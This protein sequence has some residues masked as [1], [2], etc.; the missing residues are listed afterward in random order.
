LESKPS[1]NHRKVTLSAS[2]RKVFIVH[3]HD[4]GAREKVAR[5]LEKIDLQPIIL[6]EQASSGKTI[7]EKI[8]A[9]A[10]VGFAVVLV[11]PDDHGAV[12]GDQTQPRARQNVVLEL[13]Y[14]SAKLGRESVCILRKGNTEIPSDFAGVV[15]ID[16]DEA[17]HWQLALCRELK[18][19]GFAIDMNQVI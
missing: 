19:A 1:N 14:F 16:L 18:A 11:T 8:E 5:F 4:E 7:L 15:W 17:G 9:H 12:K 2:S 6:H 10:D 13:G 3:G